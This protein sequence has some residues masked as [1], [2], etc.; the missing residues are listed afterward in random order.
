MEIVLKHKKAVEMS[1]DEFASF[2][3]E[4][5]DYRIERDSHHHI[6]VKESTYSYMGKYNAEI[7]RQ[8]C[9][10]N[11]N[12][13]AGYAFD[14]SAGFTLKNDAIL[15]PDA[16]WIR[17]ERWNLLTENEK[18]SYSR[19]CPD[20]VIEL[21][22]H[23]DTIKALQGKMQE[24]LDNGCRLAWLIVAEEQKA[25]VYRP[26]KEIKII[27]GFDSILSGEDI[28]PGFKLD[29]HELKLEL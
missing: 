18:R 23:T 22:S 19:L 4:H 5:R 26:N 12:R 20:F 6:I 29:L 9:N 17:K 25:Y 16:A 11:H 13:K 3:S 10:W 14:S 1:D 21:K 24:W 2:C 8:L 28:L 7:N 15:S 27:T